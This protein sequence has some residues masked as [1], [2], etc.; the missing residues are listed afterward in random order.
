MLRVVPWSFDVCDAD[1]RNLASLGTGL[2]VRGVGAAS[3]VADYS[4]QLAPH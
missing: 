1:V 2:S 3:I 4:K